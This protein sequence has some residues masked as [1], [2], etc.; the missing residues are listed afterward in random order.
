MRGRDCPDMMLSLGIYINTPVSE[1]SVQNLVSIC[2]YFTSTKH[3]RAV[4]VENERR[5]WPASIHPHDSLYLD[6]V[7]AIK[8]QQAGP[9]LL[10][11]KEL[12]HLCVV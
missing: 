8:V 7:R 11:S 4:I 10:I 9:C 3:A 5:D 12:V 6:S 2:S 1:Q